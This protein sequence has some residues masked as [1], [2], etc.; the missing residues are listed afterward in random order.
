MSKPLSFGLSSVDTSGLDSF[1][2]NN[3]Y[4]PFRVSDSFDSGNNN[5][6]AP[7]FDGDLLLSNNIRKLD[8]ENYAKGGNGGG[9]KGGGN[10]G[11]GGGGDGTLSKYISGAEGGYNI[12]INFKGTW[13]V[14]LQQAFIDSSEFL[15]STIV[16]DLA[17]VF[18][19]GKVID[20]IKID[21]TLKEIDGEGGV[22]GQAGATAVRTS[23]YLPATAIMEFDV[24]DA[25]TFNQAGLWDDIVTHEMIHSIGFS[26]NIWEFL[27]LITGKGGENPLFVGENATL[28]YEALFNAVNAAGVALEQDGGAGTRDSHWDEETFI[29]ELMTGYINN[30]NYISDMTIAALEDMGYDTVFDAADYLV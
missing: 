26:A 6:Y 28:A 15:S 22:L 25:S 19:R 13:T 24:A 30:E 16:G 18:Y 11:G 27:G 5:G 2:S 7:R 12:E 10:G 8:T 1:S 9:G 4:N 21:A 23:N 14:D 17:D 3:H 29:N 20:D